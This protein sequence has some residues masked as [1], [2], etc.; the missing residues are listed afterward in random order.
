[1]LVLLIVM[2]AEMTTLKKFSPAGKI[3]MIPTIMK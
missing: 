2:G 3:D 1:M